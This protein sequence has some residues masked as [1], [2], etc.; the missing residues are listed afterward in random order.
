ML[1]INQA[2][3]A[4]LC[5]KLKSRQEEL[6]SDMRLSINNENCA[7]S[8]YNMVLLPITILLPS[9]ILNKEKDIRRI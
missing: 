4:Y 1:E 2:Y 9:H 6:I 7:I 8:L 5:H 3:L